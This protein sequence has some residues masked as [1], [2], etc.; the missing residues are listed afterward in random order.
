MNSVWFIVCFR[1]P[2]IWGKW[3]I[4]RKIK[5]AFL[6]FLPWKEIRML[7]LILNSNENRYYEIYSELKKKPWT[8]FFSE[9]IRL[10]A[11]LTNQIYFQR[12]F[13]ELISKSWWNMMVYAEKMGKNE[14]S[15]STRKLL[16]SSI[17]RDV[18]N[19]Q[20]ES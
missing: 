3:Q 11:S 4:W 16:T 7:R 6:K 19:W 8:S 13:S 2:V 1:L 15:Q 20:A 5:E 10:P 17:N 9:D 14:A 12:Y 18:Y